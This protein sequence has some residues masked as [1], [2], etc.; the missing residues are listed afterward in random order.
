MKILVAVQQRHPYSFGDKCVL[1][2]IIDSC[3]KTIV[4]PDPHIMSFEQFLIQCMIMLKTV[5]E[6]K[7]YKATLTGRVVDEN[8][9]TF[10]QMKKN[11]SSSVSRLLASLFYHDRVILLCNV[12]IRR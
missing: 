4:D 7:E 3:V 5:L 11:I 1:Q 2:P 9:S 10:E 12:L 6:C 8:G